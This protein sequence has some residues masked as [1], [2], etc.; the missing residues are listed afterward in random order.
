M[1]DDGEQR[2]RPEADLALTPTELE[3]DTWASWWG[4]HAAIRDLAAAGITGM[5][6]PTDPWTAEDVRYWT[7]SARYEP[8]RD[9]AELFR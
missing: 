4:A 5:D 9:V 1:A 8:W 6:V 7:G 3:S 2:R